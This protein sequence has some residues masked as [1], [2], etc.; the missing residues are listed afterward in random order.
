MLHVLARDSAF[1][2]EP[3]RPATFGLQSVRS[4]LPITLAKKN[5]LVAL[6]KS[7]AVR[8]E[9]RHFFKSL[10]YLHRRITETDI[11]VLLQHVAV[12][13]IRPHVIRPRPKPRPG[14]S[15]PMPRPRLSAQ[16]NVRPRPRP[17]MFKARPKPR[18]KN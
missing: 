12:M 7:G 9:H 10:A 5:D 1:L 4:R 11:A 15:W 8:K 18:P 13:L 3:T 17:G 2:H 14:N 6:C 16:P